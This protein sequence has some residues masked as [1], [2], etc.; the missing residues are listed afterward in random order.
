MKQ[1]QY[2][3]ENMRTLRNELRKVDLWRKTKITSNVVFQIF[4]ELLNRD[5]IEEICKAIEEEVPGALYMGCSTNGNIIE[6]RLGESDIAITCTIFEYP[7]TKTEILQYTLTDDTA[8]AV[9]DDL[10]KKLE[11]RP[12][13]KSIEMLVTIRGM[14]MTVFCDK[15]KAAREDISIY[16]GG[17]FSSDLDDNQACVFSNAGEYS[18]SGVAFLLTGGDDFSVYT[19]YVTGWKPLGKNFRV[20]KADRNIIYELNGDPAYDVYYNYLNIGND[21]HFFTNTLEFPFFYEHNGIWILRAPIAAE[22]DGALVMTS[23]VDENVNANL[24]YGDPPTILE[25]IRNT[26]QEVLAFRPETIRL[27]SC[28]ARRTFWG[29]DEISKESAPFQ[30]IAQTSGFYTSGEFLRTNGFVNQ[31]NVTLVIAAM[32]EGCGSD[33]CATLDVSSTE[34]SGK[35]SLINRLAT[36]IDTATRELEEANEKLEFMAISDG[37]TQLYNRKEIQRRIK[38]R[39]KSGEPLSLVMMDIDNFKHVNDKYGHKEGD[40][41][42]IKLSDQLR[43]GVEEHGGK[44][45]AGRWGGEEFMLMMPYPL[46][47]AV[48]AAEEIRKNFEANEFPAAGHRTVSLGVTEAIPGES[49]DAL[50]VRVDSALYEAKKTGKNKYVIL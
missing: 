50:L 22:K 12:W 26:G 5:L 34:M 11:D 33:E 49:L 23:D 6:G 42:I 13:V 15:L 7:S 47:D 10:L 31:H 1:F 30:S 32:R 37:M 27:F 20:T 48:K 21:E 8:D 24:A 45:S 19:T 2:L 36:F 43:A 16:G 46:S 25:S 41:V 35:I 4:S 40:L 39:L 28:A 18:E 44:S 17:A 29:A 9:T 3:F 38:E 14:S